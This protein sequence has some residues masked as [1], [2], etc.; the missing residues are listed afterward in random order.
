MRLGDDGLLVVDLG[1]V[2]HRTP[3][4]T[5]GFVRAAAFFSFSTA[6]RS[7][8]LADSLSSLAADAR[9]SSDRGFFVTG[10]FVT[11]GGSPGFA[12][13]AMVDEERGKAE[14]T[15][16]WRAGHGRFWRKR[17]EGGQLCHQ[18]AGQGGQGGAS[19]PSARCL[20]GRKLASNLG[21]EWVESG[22]KTNDGPFATTRWEAC[23]VHLP[24]KTWAN[25][26][27]SRVG[28]GLISLQSLLSIRSL[29]GGRLH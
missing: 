28:V 27:G 18:R 9:E 25:R 16:E 22:Q 6:H 3:Q 29:P 24:P 8:L 11:G 20:L 26:M 21:W 7:L 5:L 2:L 4:G 15:G 10:F 12:S 1:L 13:S 23:F 19:R 17:R 14:G